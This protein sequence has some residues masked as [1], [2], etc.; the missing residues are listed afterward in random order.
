[1]QITLFWRNAG[2]HVGG[3]AVDHI[4]GSVSIFRAPLVLLSVILKSPREVSLWD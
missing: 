3:Q 4:G 1:M 2:G